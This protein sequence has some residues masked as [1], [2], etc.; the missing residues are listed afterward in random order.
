[1][2]VIDEDDIVATTDPVAF[3]D[4]TAGNGIGFDTAKAMR[5]GRAALTNAFGSELVD[6]PVPL[7]IEYWEDIDPTPATVYSFVT[8]TADTCTGLAP[9]DFG[10]ANYSGN[11]DPGETTV[12]GVTLT[13]GSGSVLLTAPN[14]GNEGE[15]D[16]VGQATIPSYLYYD[17]DNDTAHDNPPSARAT[18]GIYSGSPRRIYLR[19]L[20]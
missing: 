3:G 11:L 7:A 17:W 9:A 12:S 2:R 8:H 15:V 10:F 4:D 5:W 14:S 13:A 1:M 20:Y 18:F 6:L 16:V 19:E